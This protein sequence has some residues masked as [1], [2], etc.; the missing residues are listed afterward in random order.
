MNYHEHN[1]SI[2]HIS[3]I[4]P[5]CNNALSEKLNEDKILY[6]SNKDKKPRSKQHKRLK[7]PEFFFLLWR[8]SGGNI[9]W[10]IKKHQQKKTRKSS[11]KLCNGTQWRG[12]RKCIM[13]KNYIFGNIQER[14]PRRN[15]MRIK[16][17]NDRHP[18]KGIKR[19]ITNQII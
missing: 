16:L 2:L 9:A 14:K 8:F 19:N 18:M 5:L 12:S 3:K 7:I 17:Y 1:D 4:Q 10:A 11:R 15:I 6:G 13:R